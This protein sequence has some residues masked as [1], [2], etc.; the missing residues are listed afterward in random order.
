M[1]LKGFMGIR[2]EAA[3]LLKVTIIVPYRM[4]SGPIIKEIDDD[5]LLSRREGSSCNCHIQNE[6]VADYGKD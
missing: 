6:S 2:N 4:M 3:K 1:D 5:R